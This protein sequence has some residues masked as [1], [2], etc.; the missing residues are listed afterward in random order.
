MKKIY[1]PH[2]TSILTGA[3]A[4]L[5][6][7]HPGFTIPSG[8]QGLI[9]SICVLSATSVQAL[10]FVKRNNLEGNIILAQHLSS[11]VAASVMGDTTSADATPKA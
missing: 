4:V 6:L 10:H 2:I 5:S 3:G 7:V 8:V 11:Q 1:A 9:A